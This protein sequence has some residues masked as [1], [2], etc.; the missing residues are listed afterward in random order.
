MK[1]H[2]SGALLGLLSAEGRYDLTHMS[3]WTVATVESDIR[4]LLHRE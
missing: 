1:G 3:G 4:Y 2:L